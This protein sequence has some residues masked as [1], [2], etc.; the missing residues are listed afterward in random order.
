MSTLVDSILFCSISILFDSS[1]FNS[2]LSCYL[3]LHYSIVTIV[4][5]TTIIIIITMMMII[6][7]YT[8]L[9]RSATGRTLCLRGVPG[10]GPGP[11]GGDL[12]VFPAPVSKA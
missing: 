5:T 7:I 1:L 9:Q 2:I 11:E 10:T 3:I 6:I 4:I 8:T 12:R